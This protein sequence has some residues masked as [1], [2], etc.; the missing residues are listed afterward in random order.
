MELGLEVRIGRVVDVA[1]AFDGQ[2]HALGRRYVYRIAA[3]RPG[4]PLSP[5]AALP[6]RP[7]RRGPRPPKERL[8]LEVFEWDRIWPIAAGFDPLRAEEFAALLRGRHNFASFMGSPS[9]PTAKLK[10]GQM[11]PVQTFHEP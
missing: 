11:A 5:Q 8:R 9:D 6:V 10:A 3:L 1:E 2:K 4:V 7:S